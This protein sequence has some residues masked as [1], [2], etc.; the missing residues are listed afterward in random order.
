MGKRNWK[1]YDNAR[2]LDWNTNMNNKQTQKPLIVEQTL[3]EQLRINE[4]EIEYRKS[5]MNFTE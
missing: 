2:R 1:A 3:S 4:R 5:L